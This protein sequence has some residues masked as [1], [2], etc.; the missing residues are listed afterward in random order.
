MMKRLSVFLL[1]LAVVV[2]VNGCQ[3]VQDTDVD[4]ADKLEELKPV[5][6]VQPVVAVPP[7]P[8]D[9][10][11]DPALMG[12]WKFEETTGTKVA[13]SS[14]YSRKGELKEGL[15]FEK[16][17]VAGKVGK[18]LRF[19]GKNDLVQISGYKGVTGTK[20]RTLAAWIKTKRGR[21]EIMS[22]GA[23]DAGSMWIF[24]FI[25][26]RPGVTPKGGYFYMKP[27]VDDDKW[28][29]VAVVVTDAD[30]P[31]LHDHVTLYL[32]GQEPE[33]DDIGLLDLLPIE[34]GAEIDVRIGKGFQ[35]S[36]DEVR[37]Y[38]RALSDKEIAKLAVPNTNK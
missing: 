16:D 35:G 36:I 29:H 28:Y 2:F 34:T 27:H 6:P 25:R 9:L 26:S 32:N 33:L 37:I 22:W 11:T 4:G 20:A 38:E 8:V 24:C 14:P 10:D 19:D 23:D 18:A 30:L 17:S 1:V 3:N 15:T 12:W 13:D 21:G 7:Q 5:E 31:N